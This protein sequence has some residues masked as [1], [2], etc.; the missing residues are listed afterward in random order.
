[1]VV[2]RDVAVK[3]LKGVRPNWNERRRMRAIKDTGLATKVVLGDSKEGSYAV[4]KKYKPNM[5]C[6][7]YDQARLKKDL[8]QRMGKGKQGNRLPKIPLYIL[9]PYKAEIFHT[10]IRHK[11]K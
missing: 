3:R 10:S 11:R 4:L 6:L 9:K 1:M 2:A 7:G 5:I 8:E